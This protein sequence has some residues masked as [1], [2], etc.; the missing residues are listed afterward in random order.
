MY[1]RQIYPKPD[2]EKIK[3]QQAF[4]AQ[5]EKDQKARKD[6][7]FQTFKRIT[8]GNPRDFEVLYSNRPLR[9]TIDSTLQN[10]DCDS[11]QAAAIG[12]ALKFWQAAMSKTKLQS[13]IR[14]TII[15]LRDEVVEDELTRRYLTL[16]SSYAEDPQRIRRDVNNYINQQIACSLD[17]LGDF[18]ENQ[19]LDP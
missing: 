15:L 19:F 2:R 12:Y 8:Q 16:G 3:S 13:V 7:V 1:K 11:G 18:L 9:Y 5:Q 14:Q 17:V 6:K 10:M 4:K